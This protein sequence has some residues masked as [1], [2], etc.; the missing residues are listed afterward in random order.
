MNPRHSNRW[1]GNRFRQRS[2]GSVRKCGGRHMAKLNPSIRGSIWQ[3]AYWVANRTVGHPLLE[4]VNY[5]AIFEE[6]SALEAAFAV[7]CNALEVDEQGVVSRLVCPSQ[8]HAASDCDAQSPR[9]CCFLVIGAGTL[10][11]VV[12]NA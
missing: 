1:L 8:F 5:A 2:S 4:G 11:H 10:V 6:P 3:F 9:I 12:R 7:Y